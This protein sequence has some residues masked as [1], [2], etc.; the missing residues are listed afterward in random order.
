MLGGSLVLAAHG[1]QQPTDGSPTATRER[2]ERLSLRAADR[3]RALETEADELASRERTLLGDIR[4]LEVDRQIKTE[5]LAAIDGD[6]AD[7]TDQ[8]EDTTAQM[9]ELEREA[10]AQRPQ[11]EARLV[12]L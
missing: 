1:E 5:E 9:N 10:D 7:T 8:L 12:A 4:R 2:V 3:M 6:L 11:V